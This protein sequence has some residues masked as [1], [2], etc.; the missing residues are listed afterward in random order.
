MC[1]CK[2]L[3]MSTLMLMKQ[4]TK[5]LLCDLIDTNINKIHNILE[6]FLMEFRKMW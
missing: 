6:G 2:H 5:L 3:M 1:L 4:W